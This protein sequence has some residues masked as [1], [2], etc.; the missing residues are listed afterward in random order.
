MLK[1]KKG[2]FGALDDLG[3]GVIYFI[4]LVAV[5]VVLLANFL[6]QAQISSSSNATATVNT[7]INAL[8]GLAGWAP[9]IIIIGVVVVILAVLTQLRR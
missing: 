4:I 1:D 7:G 6:T 2:M 8:Q 3:H 9:I 5:G